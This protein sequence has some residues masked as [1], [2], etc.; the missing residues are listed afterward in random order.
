MANFRFYRNSSLVKRLLL[1]ALAFVG[2]PL[3]LFTLLLWK[4][5][6]A[7]KEREHQIE[8]E[9]I[10]RS[11]QKLSTDWVVLKKSQLRLLAHLLEEQAD[12]RTLLQQTPEDSILF[13]TGEGRYIYSSLPTLEGKKN[14]FPRE[15]LLIDRLAPQEPPSLI[16]ITDGAGF[17]IDLSLWLQN[18]SAFEKPLIPFRLSIEETPQTDSTRSQSFD[19]PV[20]GYRFVVTL[21]PGEEPT[22]PS[23]RLVDSAL[24]FLFLFLLVG[25]GLTLWLARRMAQPLRQLH[26]VM[27]QA[28][29]GNLAARYLDDPWGFEVN[30]L[31]AHFNQTAQ[32]LVEQTQAKDRL[33]GEL[34]IGREIQRNLFPRVYPEIRGIEIGSAFLPARE[35]AGDFYDL[36]LLDQQRLV[37]SVADASDKGISACLYSLLLRS[38]LRSQLM[39]QEDLSEA[40]FKTNRFFCRD[41][42]DS[43]NFATLWIGIY[44]AHH[45]KLTY[46]SAG[47]PPALLLR[48]GEMPR[49][50]GQ[51]QGALGIQEWASPPSVHTELLQSG[52][53]LLLYTDGVTEAQNPAGTLFGKEALLKFAR[54]LKIK[55]PQAVVDLLLKEIEQHTQGAGYTDDIALL[56][57]KID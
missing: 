15:G 32:A 23:I 7:L 51:G 16:L 1:A 43:G 24:H 25:G 34:A 8:L 41:T 46:L 30:Q 39:S 4:K 52:D 22:V 45:Q 18:L 38:Y 36:F 26:Q 31:G 27:D 10:G 9:L 12:P 19:S 42:A 47:H 35:V 44:D 49:F 57:I 2:V 29:G 48:T 3:L 11:L 17:A 13:F 56:S 20:T 54:E 21:L 28:A 37:L 50:L 14:S 40:L 55:T 53:L 33:A 6:E 5:E